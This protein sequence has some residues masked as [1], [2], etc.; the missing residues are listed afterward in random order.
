MGLDVS[1]EIATSFLRVSFLE[2][3]RQQSFRSKLCAC[4]LQTCHFNGFM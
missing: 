1:E 2:R 4:V 3:C